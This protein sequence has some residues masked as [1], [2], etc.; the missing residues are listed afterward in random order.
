MRV[1]KAV[2]RGAPKVRDFQRSRVYSWERANVLPLSSDPL[3]LAQCEALVDR[4]YRACERP[5]PANHE[6]SPPRVTDGRGRRHAAGSREVIKLP[7]WARTR[8]I[9]LHECAHG[10]ASDGHGPEFVAVY[11]DLLE[12]F[13]SFERSYLERTLTEARV[14]CAGLR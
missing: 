7:R 11:L 6:W 1:R 8:P 14:R 2:P 3:T 10:M 4:V 9:V 12:H 13:A 5:D